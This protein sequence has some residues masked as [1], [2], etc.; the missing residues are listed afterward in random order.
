M[1]GFKAV[2]NNRLFSISM[3]KKE[4]FGF[5][6]LELLFVILVISIVAAA[7]VKRIAGSSS[8]TALKGELLRITDTLSFARNIALT[9]KSTVAV[10]FYPK[11]NTNKTSY[12]VARLDDL[13]IFLEEET[14]FREINC[15][16][17]ADESDIDEIRFNKFGKIATFIND[18]QV[19]DFGIFDA[20]I[21]LNSFDDKNTANI[22]I[23]KDSGRV[24]K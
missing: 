22:T 20:N 16:L 9:N 1:I 12:E 17:V 2:F 23:L 6:L 18:E 13:S 11:G 14:I 15:S 24:I 4:P 5:T 21:A 10:Y 8:Y 19:T 3:K 7:G